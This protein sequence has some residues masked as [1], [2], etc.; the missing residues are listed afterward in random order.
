MEKQSWRADISDVKEV[1]QATDDSEDGSSSESESDEC[2]RLQVGKGKKK[3]PAASTKPHRQL[4][5]SPCLDRPS[6]SQC[7]T[8]QDLREDEAS[9]GA[10]SK[11]AS[12]REYQSKMEFA[13]KLGYSGEQVETV[14]NKL[15]AA[16]LINDVL[17]ELVRLGN[18][19]ELE[20]QP[21]SSAALANISR[22]PCVKENTSPEA[23]VEEDSMDTFDNLRPI[24]IDGSNVAMR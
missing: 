2:Q 22:P 5:R 14:L 23:S 11:T 9:T 8:A 6:F 18:K 3:E 4:C 10:G 16:A 21:C 19:V 20:I 24:V 1:Q 7:S 17:A 12:D 15:G 13:L